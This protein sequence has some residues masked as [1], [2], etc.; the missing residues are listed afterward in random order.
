MKCQFII[1]AGSFLNHTVLMMPCSSFFICLSW[2]AKYQKKK[3]TICNM[4]YEVF[5]FVNM[6]NPLVIFVSSYGNGLTC[7]LCGARE[8]FHVSFSILPS[9]KAS[10]FSPWASPETLIS[11]RNSHAQLL[12]IRPKL[13]KKKKKKKKKEEE[14]EEGFAPKPVKTK[15]GEENP[16]QS[17]LVFCFVSSFFVSKSL[18]ITILISSNCNWPHL[19]KGKMEKLAWKKITCFAHEALSVKT[20]RN[21]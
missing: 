11:H 3:K 2:K 18:L 19:N 12:G 10:P 14:E 7:G 16:D 13:K 20:D 1:L 9:V 5:Q 17:L 15:I 6:A 8:F 21:Y 4:P